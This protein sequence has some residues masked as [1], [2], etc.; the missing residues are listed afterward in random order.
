MEFQNYLGSDLLSFSKCF[1]QGLKEESP[2]KEE[3]INIPLPHLDN[4]I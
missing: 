1:K 2:E 4:I 3:R